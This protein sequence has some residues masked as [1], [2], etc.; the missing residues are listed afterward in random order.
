MAVEGSEER[1]DGKLAEA[2][3]SERANSGR[4]EFSGGAEAGN[5]DVSVKRRWWWGCLV[6]VRLLVGRVVSNATPC[7]RLSA[8]RCA[9]R[10]VMM[11]SEPLTSMH[12]RGS[13]LRFG[14]RL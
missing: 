5:E 13:V 3:G 11:V 10:C 12:P 1:W 6:F 14:A 7:A 8:R 4:V 2:E 9:V